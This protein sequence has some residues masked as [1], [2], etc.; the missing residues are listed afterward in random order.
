MEHPEKASTEMVCQVHQHNVS[1]IAINQSGTKIATTSTKVRHS[2]FFNC[3]TPLVVMLVVY[4]SLSLIQGTLI[5]IHSTH[6]RQMLAEFR[7]GV[8]PANIYW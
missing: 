1:C 7:R 4:L 8:E 5:R 6:T 2:V 3:H